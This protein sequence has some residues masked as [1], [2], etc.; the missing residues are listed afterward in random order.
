M[1]A[2]VLITYPLAG[3]NVVAIQT[4]LG[5]IAVYNLL[6][7]DTKLQRFGFF[8]SRAN[9]LVV[10][11]LFVLGVVAFTGGFAS[12]Y[13]IMFLLLILGT[14]A[15]YG[16]PG[17]AYALS[18]QVVISL[19]LLHTEA[20]P[21]PGSSEFRFIINL[22]VIII[23]TLVAGQTVRSR[24]EEYLLEG[25]FSLGVETERQRLRAVIHSLSTPFVAID[26]R[27]KIYLYNAAALSLLNTHKDINGLPAG[28]LL[29]L[30]DK[31]GRKLNLLHLLPSGEN[32]ISRQDLTYE[33]SDGSTIVIDLTV[34]R[35]HSSEPG[36]NGGY[37]AMFK[38]ITKEKSL[39][40]QRDEFISVISHELRTPLAIAEANL[41][42][43]LLPGYAT[44]EPKAHVL[45]EQSH[46]NVIFLSQLIQDLTTISRAERGDLKLDLELVSAT[47]LVEDLARD[48][49]PQAQ[50]KQLNLDLELGDGLGSIV[51]SPAELREILQNFLTN[52]IKYTTTGSIVLSA[53]RVEGGTE[54]AVKDSGIGISASDKAKIFNKFFRSEDYRT[55]HTGGTGLGLYITHKLAQKLEVQL[56]F[57]SRLN[58][59]STFKV[60]VPVRQDHAAALAVAAAA[61]PKVS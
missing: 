7:Y 56:S 13:Y 54:F 5:F 55:R 27:G 50:A 19:M 12:P 45:L 46:Q 15:S 36:G 10:D 61:E 22:I 18:G 35:V 51:T 33:A 52:A 26:H 21:A 44:I 6:R 14:I 53:A 25:Q 24:D 43:A 49:R 9:S 57:T 47:A 58:H 32:T 41:S 34:T 23:F 11:H 16:I 4:M 28:D 8:G 29:P 2:L 30:R 20:V 17:L 39:N 48:Y 31:H 3:P 37:M 40:E 59:G 60:L 1:L 42:T 38:D